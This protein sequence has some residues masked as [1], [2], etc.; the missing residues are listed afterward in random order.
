MKKIGYIG[1]GKMGGTISKLL[2]ESGYELFGFDPN[3]KGCK[4]FREISGTILSS[5]KNVANETEI[6]LASLPNDGIVREVVF[7]ENG[8]SETRKKIIFAD[9]STV[10]PET[11]KEI[12]STLQKKSISYL[13]A[14][15][16]GNPKVVQRKELVLMCG[17]KKTSYNKCLPIFRTFT[18]KQF[19]M[20]SSGS[21]SLMKMVV[22][23]IS[24]INRT[25]IGEGFSLGKKGGLSG[26]TMLQVLKEGAAYSKQMDLKGDRI[27][28]SDYSSPEST[29]QQ[30]IKTANQI[31]KTANDLNHPIPMTALRTQLYQALASMGHAKDD[32]SS[33]AELFN[34]MSGIK[35]N[36]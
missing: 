9:L 22:N 28:R 31:L 14:T 20:G 12:A 32:A 2:L 27:L 36:S 10:Y 13:D 18:K 1:L 25:A 34:K 7:G 21:G 35:P 11:T 24:E 33:I 4:K 15:V 29:V 16:S 8:V 17:G 3:K 6:V 5:P 26:E 23:T 30:C 19:Y